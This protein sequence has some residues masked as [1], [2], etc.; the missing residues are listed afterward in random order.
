MKENTLYEA[1]SYA[2]LFEAYVAR[3][4]GNYRSVRDF[5]L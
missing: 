1:G 4:F 2:Q 5:T 3:F